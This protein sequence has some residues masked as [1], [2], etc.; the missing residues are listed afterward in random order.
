MSVFDRIHLVTPILKPR[1]IEP[2][3]LEGERGVES[4]GCGGNCDE[5]DS[6]GVDSGDAGEGGGRK[7][8]KFFALTTTV[9]SPLMLSSLAPPSAA[10]SFAALS[11]APTFSVIQMM[12]CT[13]S[14][15]MT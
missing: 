10:F 2:K 1:T 6:D 15:M 13:W 14:G 12:P 8:E 3:V 11:A 4:W 9:L 7:G 5:G